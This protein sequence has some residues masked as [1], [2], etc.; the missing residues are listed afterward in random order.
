MTQ[1]MLST[2]LLLPHPFGP[3]TPVIPWS[4]LTIVL[5]AKLLNPFISKFFNLTV[6]GLFIGSTLLCLQANILVMEERKID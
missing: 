3:I 6:S 4:K 1:R 2:M 5:S